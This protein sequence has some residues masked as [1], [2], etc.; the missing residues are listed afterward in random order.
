MSI[1]KIFCLVSWAL[2]SID[3]VESPVELSY[4]TLCTIVILFLVWIQFL[5]SNKKGEKAVQQSMCPSD[6]NTEFR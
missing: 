5:F 1:L 3:L 6:R 2:M 4:M